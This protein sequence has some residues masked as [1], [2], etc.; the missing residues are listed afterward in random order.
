M[1]RGLAGLLTALGL[2]LGVLVAPAGSATG[3][4]ATAAPEIRGHALLGSTLRVQPGTWQPETVTLTYQWTRDGEPVVGATDPTY[5]LAR[6]DL[7]TEVGVTETATDE[8]GTTGNAEAPPV[9]PI[10]KPALTL[11]EEPTIDGVMRYQR[12]VTAD[13]GRV[14]PAATRTRYRWLRDG[15]AVQGSRPRYHLGYQ[16]VGHRLRL[17]VTY[18]R[19]GYRTLRVLSAKRLVGQRVPVKKR[20]TYSV[21]TKGD[22]SASVA[23][24]KRLAQGTYDDPR[25][26]RAA[27]YSFHR[28]ARG[29]DFT[30]VLATA[31]MVPTYSSECSSAWSCRVGR[32]VIINQTRWQ[33]ASPA[34]NRAGRSLR[35]YR[36]MVVN[37]ETGH[38]LGHPHAS[39]S[40][41]GPAP[42][43]M[44]Q[45]KGRGGCSFN[46]FPLPSERWTTR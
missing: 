4:M 19:D 44:Q 1:G 7:G 6:A 29:G 20:F 14:Q 28:V 15:T 22:V 11:A 24:F 33:H 2:V 21:R 17:Q 36:H 26:W 46:P 18:R 5:L 45:S 34:W 12:V 43:M 41:S 3:P 10:R 30:L 38:W 13:L 9:G 25:G 31:A 27:G 40:G 35:D 23:T 8:S 37:H 16:D 42:V 39:C 32:F